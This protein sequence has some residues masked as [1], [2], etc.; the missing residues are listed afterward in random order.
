MA[1]VDNLSTID[2]AALKSNFDFPVLWSDSFVSVATEVGSIDV[3]VKEQQ[4]ESVW[5]VQGEKSTTR[6]ERE[7]NS[8]SDDDE[9]IDS[10]WE[11]HPST[12]D[13]TL[14]K[15]NTLFTVDTVDLISNV[16][17]PVPQPNSSV[18]IATRAGSS[19]NNIKEQRVESVWEVQGEESATRKERETY[20]I[21]PDD[22][23]FDTYKKALPAVYEHEGCVSSFFSTCGLLNIFF[24]SPKRVDMILD[25][26]LSKMEQEAKTTHAKTDC[27][28]NTLPDN[29]FIGKSSP[30]NTVTNEF[31]HKKS[32]FNSVGQSF[33][34]QTKIRSPIDLVNQAFLFQDET[35]DSQLTRTQLKP[36]ICSTS[37]DPKHIHSRSHTKL[38]KMMKKVRTSA[39][40]LSR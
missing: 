26:A 32:T 6:K 12:Q 5:E 20:T 36:M 39:K 22:E 16:E 28:L 14:S 13:Y 25:E 37:L 10:W 35:F 33:L 23:T 8:F 24:C 4:N 2:T 17:Y 7:T 9:S 21:S 29:L 27:S 1:I 30:T 19:A 34:Y 3:D 38:D 11:I 40:N 31:D 18:S 15:S